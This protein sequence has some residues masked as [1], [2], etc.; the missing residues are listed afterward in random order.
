M[1]V[2]EFVHE[3][4]VPATVLVNAEGATVVLLHTVT[5]DGVVMLGKGFTVTLPTAVSWHPLGSV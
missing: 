3:Y 1:V 2:F 4:V 5:F